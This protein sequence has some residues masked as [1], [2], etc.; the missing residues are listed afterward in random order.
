MHAGGGNDKCLWL[1]EVQQMRIVCMQF[2][3]SVLTKGSYIPMST[4]SDQN[5]CAVSTFPHQQRIQGTH[6]TYLEKL[7]R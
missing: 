4:K 6:W 7:N 3:C 5:K 1:H 2:K